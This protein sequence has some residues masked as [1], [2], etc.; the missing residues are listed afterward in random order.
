M[1]LVQGAQSG[2][3]ADSVTGSLL[4]FEPASEIGCL[5]E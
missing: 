2:Y 1:T 4:P 3:E 5:F